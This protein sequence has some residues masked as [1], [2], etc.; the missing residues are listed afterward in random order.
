MVPLT[1]KPCQNNR[2]P[3][4]GLG[5]FMKRILDIILSGIALLVLAFPTLVVTFIIKQ[6]T[7]GSATFKQTRVGLNGR[8]F[9]CYKFRTM[10]H[11][12][13]EIK[14]EEQL[15]NEMKGPVFKMKDDPRITP[16]GKILRKYSLD[17][18]PQLW[19]VFKGDMSLVGPRPPL[20]SEV[21]L[22]KGWQRRRLSMRPGIT[23][24]WQVGGRNRIDDFDVWAKLDLK[25]I[26]EW[27][28]WLDIEI[29]FKT[30]PAVIKG[31]GL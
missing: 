17:E 23:C 6:S 5:L 3:K 31:T 10:Y 27:K 14:F 7:H 28:F 16:V 21:D 30:V 11:E 8:K 29:L 4:Y 19:N 12:L 22:Y 9:L 2:P 26:D 24:I 18:L 13:Q 1:M 25:Y 15:K 20:P